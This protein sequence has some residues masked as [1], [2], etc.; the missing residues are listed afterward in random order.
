MEY[1]GQFIQES[2][3]GTIGGLRRSL[4]QNKRT[5]SLNPMPDGT[6][7]TLKAVYFKTGRVNFQYHNDWGTTGAMVVYETV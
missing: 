2:A 7:R 1:P 5:L 4:K 3:M 6:C